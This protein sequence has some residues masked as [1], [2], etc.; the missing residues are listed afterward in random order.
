MSDAAAWLGRPGVQLALALWCGAG[1]LVGTLVGW[2]RNRTLLGAGTG[3]LLGPLGWWLT[4]LL[5]ARFREC[6]ACSRPIRVQATSCPKCGADV[7]AVELR[8]SRSSMKGSQTGT[9]R[10]W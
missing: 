5:P 8:S 10:P 7:S 6:P 9:R 2:W 1:L 4:W 3:L